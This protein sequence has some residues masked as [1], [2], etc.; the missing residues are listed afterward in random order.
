MVSKDVFWN[1]W[2]LHCKSNENLQNIVN[3]TD[4]KKS[5]LDDPGGT[6]NAWPLETEL[7]PAGSKRKSTGNSGRTLT[8]QIQPSEESVAWLLLLRIL[9]SMT[10]NRSPGT[11]CSTALL[12]REKGP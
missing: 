1:L 12:V 8:E 11:K 4:L 3:I 6:N 5:G 7:P 9:G 10:K 2:M